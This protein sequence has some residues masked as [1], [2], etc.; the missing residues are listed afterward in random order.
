MVTHSNEEVEE[1]LP[2]LFNL[3]CHCRAALEGV[4][5]ADDE[6]KIMRSELGVIL[7]GMSVCPASRSQQC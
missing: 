6:S 7:R 2:T 5:A 1:E 4:A 3:L